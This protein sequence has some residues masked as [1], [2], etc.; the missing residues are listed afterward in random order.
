VS[1]PARVHITGVSGAGKSTL[2]RRIGS[3]FDLP[4]HHLDEIA[5]DPTTRERRPPEERQA[6]VA[7]IAADPRWVTDG[8]Q[9]GWTDPLCERADLIV[10]LDHLDASRASVR[11]IG[12]FTRQAW[13]EFRRQR[14][15]GKFLRVRSYGHQAR[16]LVRSLLEVH[17]FDRAPPEPEGV[18]AGS[19]TAIIAQLEPHRAKVRHCQTHGDVE[20]LLVQ[21]GV[22]PAT[23]AVPN[24][25]DA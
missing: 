24:V 13:Q 19:R 14:G 2:A 15:R 18:D 23:S 3:A 20:D 9:T 21:L 17:E 7:R 6:M 10:W 16:A 8:V 4:V 12:R 25:D 1:P 5:I 11:I 22:D